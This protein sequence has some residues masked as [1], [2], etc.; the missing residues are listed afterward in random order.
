M[1]RFFAQK[2]LSCR[3]RYPLRI[4]CIAQGLS[5]RQNEINTYKGTLGVEDV[6]PKTKRGQVRGFSSLRG[7]EKMIEVED[8]AILEESEKELQNNF[9]DSQEVVEGHHPLLDNE[10]YDYI[11]EG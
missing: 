9:G 10:D 11:G 8:N 4:Q 3:H 1:A 6:A 2:L 7:K 5:C